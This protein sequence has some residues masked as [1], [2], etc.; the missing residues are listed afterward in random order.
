MKILIPTAKEMN[1]NIESFDFEKLDLKSEQILNKILEFDEKDL[2]KFYKI[3][4]AQASIEKIRLNNIKNKTAK[5][6]KAIELFNGLMYR[7]IKR[8]NL[9]RQEE[10]YM[11]SNVFI[12]SSFYGMINAYQKISEHRLDFMQKIRLD[13]K[14][15]KD[16]WRPSYDDFVENETVIS[17]L[18]SEFEEVFS[19]DIRD[20]FIK[21]IF[22]E[23]KDN[24]FKTHSTISKKA[25]GKFLSCLIEN[26]IDDIHAIKNLEFE[27]YRYD[28][29][30]SS[31]KEYIFVAERR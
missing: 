15:L 2:A 23:K 22:M 12:T 25:R 27:D 26:N 30:L 7:N 4:T 24:Q 3:K 17:L 8:N 9:S 10:T 20:N 29:K 5:S 19:K 18:S 21:I 6:Y 13:N 14:S 1:T 16:F 28:A 11:K 31:E